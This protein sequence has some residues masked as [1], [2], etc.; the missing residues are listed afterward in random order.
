MVLCLST[1]G[2]FVFCCRLCGLGFVVLLQ[3]W[4]GW[5]FM[6]KLMQ[7]SDGSS[8]EVKPIRPKISELLR[9][10]KQGWAWHYIRVG[11]TLNWDVLVARRFRA[12]NNSSVTRHRDPSFSDT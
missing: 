10:I 6:N 3:L 8:T 5:T 2:Y 11:V 12:P 1:C 9:T 4:V 7:R